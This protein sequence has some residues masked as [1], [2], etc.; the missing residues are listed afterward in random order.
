MATEFVGCMY[1]TRS[2]F[3]H[4]TILAYLQANASVQVERYSLAVVRLSPPD[5][6]GLAS[7][8]VKASNGTTS[9]LCGSS[10]SVDILTDLGSVPSQL[11]SI[12]RGVLPLLPPSQ[13]PPCESGRELA[14]N[15]SHSTQM[16]SL[17][18]TLLYPELP[19]IRVEVNGR[20]LSRGGNV[21]ADRLADT[22][23]QTQNSGDGSS[24]STTTSSS[25]VAD[26]DS[27]LLPSAF[28]MGMQPGVPM[29]LAVVVVAEDGVTSAR[30]PITITR[31]PAAEAAPAIG[32]ASKGTG[33]SKR[34][35]SSGGTVTGAGA[36]GAEQELTGAALAPVQQQLSL[37]ELR[38]RGWPVPPALQPGCSPCPAGWA[39]AGLNASQCLMCTPGTFS[40]APL[41]T[42]CMPCRP[43]TYAYSWGSTR[44]KHCIAQTYAA[45]AGSALCTM[46]PA[47]WTTAGDGSVACD[48]PLD[49]AAA[50]AVGKRRAAVVVSFSVLLS[51][52]DFEDVVLQVGDCVRAPVPVLC[53]F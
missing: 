18:P 8:T 42:S 14:L 29:Q 40:A 13:S 9:V 41:S 23:G 27:S 2:S 28:I 15:I 17:T 32:A 38:A 20:V 7:L 46:C 33:S 19:G 48:V 12:K 22:V 51:G 4:A 5:H 35:I 39:A 37:S 34:S 53:V 1:P 26:G 11:M 25:G 24:S 44:C 6:A 16:V 52:V 36:A 43:G 10:S 49:D 45:S 31:L 47:N 50:A 3:I 30:Y 21:V